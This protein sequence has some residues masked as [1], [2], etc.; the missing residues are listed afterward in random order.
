MHRIRI[1]GHKDFKPLEIDENFLL[2]V[3]RT[4]IWVGIFAFL[5]IW[6]YLGQR[7]A[8][9]FIIGAAVSLIFLRTLEY[10]V[11]KYITPQKKKPKPMIL[12][13]AL[14]KFPLLM[15]L[16][17]FLVKAEWPNLAALVVGLGLVQAIIILKAFGIVLVN[18]VNSRPMNKERCP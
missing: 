10:A 1:K 17:Y 15:V 4:S 5:W 18:A 13:T 12:I 14:I 8:L 3:Y 11:K 7:V 9:S 16:F 6:I 2:R